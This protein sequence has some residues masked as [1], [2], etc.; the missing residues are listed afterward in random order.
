MFTLTP[1]H[2]MKFQYTLVRNVNLCPV[3]YFS[4]VP[5]LKAIA[6]VGEKN[7]NIAVCGVHWRCFKQFIMI[8]FCLCNT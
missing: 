1:G 4:N 6:A 5:H 2:E 7:L 3:N 8:L